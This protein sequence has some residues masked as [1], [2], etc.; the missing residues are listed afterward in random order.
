MHQ[1]RR[2]RATGLCR[3]YRLAFSDIGRT[4][5]DREF[6]WLFAK[7][8]IGQLLAPRKH[9]RHF[10]NVSQTSSQAVNREVVITGS[11]FPEEWRAMGNE[12]SKP[13]FPMYGAG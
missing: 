11:L 8:H 2:G 13:D 6:R 7:R 5:P 9:I 4:E 3:F 10:L 1:I 12:T